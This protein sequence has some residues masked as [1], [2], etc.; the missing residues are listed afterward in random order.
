MFQRWIW[1]GLLLL[2]ALPVE[3]QQ[4]LDTLIT[5]PEV[6][7]TASRVEVAAEEAPTRVTY[8]SRTYLEQMP[9]ASVAD[10]LAQAGHGFV[11]F[12]GTSGL[13]S[14]SIRGST[15]SQ[16][17]VLVDGFRITDPQLGQ[18]DWRLFPIDVLEGVEVGYG[19]NSALYGSGAAGGVVNLHLLDA[20]P[21]ARGR[22]RLGYG[23]WGAY[24]AGV[25]VEPTTG[26]WKTLF[27][28]GWE[29]AQGDYPYVNR[30]LFP[31]RQ[32]RRENNDYREVRLYG[33]TSYTRR[34]TQI[35]L[36]FWHLE[37]RR[38]LPGPGTQKPVGERQFD[39]ATYLLLSGTARVQDTWLR[40]GML[41][42]HGVLRYV[43]PQL[44]LDATGKTDFLQVELE[45]RRECGSGWLCGWLLA[46]ALARAVHP[47]LA[48]LPVEWQ[49]STSFYARG[50]IGSLRLFP[51]FRVER[52]IT[53]EVWI[54]I[55][56]LGMNLPLKASLILKTSLGRAFRNPTFNDRYWMPGGN[57]DLRPEKGWQLDGGLLLKR[58]RWALEF[59]AFWMDM[60]DQIIWQPQGNVWSPINKRRTRSR[61]LEVSL[62]GRQRVSSLRFRYYVG[63]TFTDARDRSAPDAPSF[64]RPL[65][66]VPRELARGH[67][68]AGWKGVQAGGWLQ[69][70]GRRYVTTDGT[71]FLSPYLLLTVTLEASVPF[72][73][74]GL[75]IKGAI[76]NLLNT[77][78]E[79]VQGYP[80]PPRHGTITITL[81]LR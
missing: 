69:Y 21:E 59:T 11:R 52:D 19:S 72:S 56:R 8:I 34:H 67:L 17:A 66:Y 51:A 32:V 53:R 48:T 54:G 50:R 29:Q 16:V 74:G 7:V 31:P 49:W 68:V 30:A 70:V 26:A 42:R 15:S 12:Y 18:V 45:A 78:Y 79:V 4:V 55:P 27:H 44:A 10:V 6:T 2:T 77:D 80:M 39:R 65:R 71:Q 61:G 37:A 33:T 43:H 62:E 25:L 1:T 36:R 35:R 5:L 14:L 40:G 75:H 57:P 28:V 58:S 3:A 13:A 47:S 60:Y 76:Q 64:N 63:Y 38:G 24:R 73:R 41:Y 20:L 9:A 22:I 23:A 46:P 81:N